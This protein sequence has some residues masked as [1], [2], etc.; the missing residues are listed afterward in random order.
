MGKMAR[1]VV[2]R[3]GVNVD[4]LVHKLVRAAAAEFTTYYYCTILRVNAIG[5]EGEG[6]KEI[7]EDARLEDRNHFEALVPRIYELGGAIPPGYQ[8]VRSRRCLPGCILAGASARSEGDADGAW[9]GRALCS[10]GLHV[11]MPDD[12]WQGPP[13]LRAVPR[14]P[15]RGDRTRGLVLGIPR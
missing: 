8:G 9:G 10:Q 12:L 4:E 5:F 1:E 2:E 11:D 7:I 14:H 3:A 13:H 6:L 15:Q